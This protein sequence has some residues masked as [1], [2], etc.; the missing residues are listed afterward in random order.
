SVWPVASYPNADSVVSG[1][2]WVKAADGSMVRRVDPRTRR[3]IASIA[4]G[5]HRR[6]DGVAI[7]AGAVWVAS[8]GRTGML[9]RI[10]PRTN[11]VVGAPI[12]LA[13]GAEA[14]AV[15]AG[16]V[17]VASGDANTVSRIDPASNRMLARIAVERP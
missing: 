13:G 14:V 10:D 2:V 17:W 1:A 6:A 7:G 16:A 12:A 8:G 3:V 5:G 9:R 15:G 4:V 11:R